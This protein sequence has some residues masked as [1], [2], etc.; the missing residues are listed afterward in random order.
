MC[1]APFWRHVMPILWS[2]SSLREEETRVED[3]LSAQAKD[4][5]IHNARGL[6]DG[7]KYGV[8]SGPYSRLEELRHIR[9]PQKRPSQSQRTPGLSAEYGP[10]L[11]H[12]ESITI[13]G[14][15]GW[16][17]RKVPVDDAVG[18]DAVHWGER[19]CSTQPRRNLTRHLGAVRSKKTV[20]LAICL[21]TL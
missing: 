15:C 14:S 9:F 13:G 17:V 20:W 19:P 2:R 1:V 4:R 18:G 7:E 11:P 16:S 12:R 21:I 5:A 10:P 3:R 8:A 6:E